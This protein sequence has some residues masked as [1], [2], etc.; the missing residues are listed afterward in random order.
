MADQNSHT[1]L[2]KGD[3]YYAESAPKRARE[4]PLTNEPWRSE[5]HEAHERDQRLQTDTERVAGELLALAPDA[6]ADFS[7]I[8]RSY[9]VVA[10]YL[11]SV[12][13]KANGDGEC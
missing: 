10:A 11:L 5:L 2:T 13:V 8:V 6:P 1:I 7:S 12:F 3:N 4:M 9:P